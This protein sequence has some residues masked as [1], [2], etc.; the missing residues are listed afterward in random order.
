[1]NFVPSR[2]HLGFVFGH[3]QKCLS[4]FCAA[5]PN[6]PYKFGSAIGT[7]QID[8]RLAVPEHMNMCWN[9]IVEEDDHTHPELAMD[10]DHLAILTHH[11]GFSTPSNASNKE[12]LE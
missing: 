8:L 7:L 10:S 3:D 2:K 1:M 9:M 4:N 12:K 6:S 5:H 11:V